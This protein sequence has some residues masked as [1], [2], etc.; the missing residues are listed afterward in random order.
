LNKT[1]AEEG[2]RIPDLL[3]T[4]ALSNS[5]SQVTKIQ[6]SVAPLPEDEKAK[7]QSQV[8]LNLP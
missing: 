4:I 2:Y 3:K 7:P 5:F 1:F 6:P 8:T